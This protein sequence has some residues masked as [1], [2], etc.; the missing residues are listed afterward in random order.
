MSPIHGVQTI[1]LDETERERERS[2]KENGSF[3]SVAPL[4]YLWIIGAM[5]F[6]SVGRDFVLD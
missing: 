2:A 4:V 6:L 1:S 5:F 3:R